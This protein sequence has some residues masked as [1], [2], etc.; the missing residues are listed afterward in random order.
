MSIK[1]YNAFRVKADNLDEVVQ[2]FFK[3]KA[4]ITQDLELCVVK[5]ILMEAIITY[6]KFTLEGD[7][8][9]FKKSESDK[10][11]LDN[12]QS[13]QNILFNKLWNKKEESFK[14]ENPEIESQVI[15]YPQPIDHFG[16]K[17]Y[18]MQVFGEDKLIETLNKK[19]FSKW[20]IEEYNYWDNTD[21]PDTITDYEWDLRRKN[22]KGIDIPLFSGIAINFVKSPKYEI[23]YMNNISSKRELVKNTLEVLQT[24]MTVDTR[25]EQYVQ[26]IKEDVAYKY[27]YDI[28]IK[29]NNLENA[30]NDDIRD[31]IIS[32]G[33]GIYFKSRDRVREDIF[34]DEEKLSF[35]EKQTQIR[36]LLKPII[37][38]EDLSK[39]GEEIVQETQLRQNK[40][41][42][43]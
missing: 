17:S 1:I 29:E 2:M 40:K 3:E 32:R 19:Y 39:K 25:V 7:N 35:A 38:F 18:L 9:P 10:H 36:K 33:M 31:F 16:E 24:T 4:Q 26:K 27:C 41:L 6:D 21:P 28:A 37:T 14:E 43:P 42:K 12:T 13:V 11:K 5:D 22:W 30:S 20:N 34:T 8:L 23:Y 15:I